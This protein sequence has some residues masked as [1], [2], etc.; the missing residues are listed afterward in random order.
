MG[1]WGGCSPQLGVPQWR[2]TVLADSGPGPADAGSPASRRCRREEVVG[3]GTQGTSLLQG[4]QNQ[5]IM[6]RHF[7]TLKTL[8]NINMQN[9]SLSIKEAINF[10]PKDFL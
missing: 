7:I 2:G 6:Y 8:F 3:T 1:S 5:A 4:K 10:I 9:M